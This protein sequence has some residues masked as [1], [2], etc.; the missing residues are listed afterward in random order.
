V[1]HCESDKSDARRIVHLP[2][3]TEGT[4]MA[5]YKYQ[6]YLATSNHQAFDQVHEPGEA[7]PYSGIYRCE[8]CGHEVTS[9]ATHPLPP[10]NHH[11]HNYNQGHIRWRL[12]VAD[13]GKPT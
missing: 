9:V 6:Q 2:G 11:Q 12:V 3:E 5:L 7:T 4:Y 1:N 8:G 10:Q 13:G